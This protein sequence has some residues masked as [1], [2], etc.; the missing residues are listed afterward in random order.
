MYCLTERNE[1]AERSFGT[2]NKPAVDV[3]K[4]PLEGITG[5]RIPLP[6]EFLTFRA[7]GVDTKIKDLEER[8]EELTGRASEKDSAFGLLKKEYEW[9]RQGK[10][11]L[12]REV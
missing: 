1:K 12:E 4:L 2:H 7:E 3:P 6:N 9:T 8:I 11:E 10:A 5:I